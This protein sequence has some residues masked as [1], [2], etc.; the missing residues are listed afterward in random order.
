MKLTLL[1][2][3][4]LLASA[5]GQYADFDHEEHL[6]QSPEPIAI[7]ARSSSRIPRGGGY[8]SAPIE[9]LPVS[10]PSYA[11]QQIETLPN[12]G[13]GGG[14]IAP[15]KQ[16]PYS[17]GGG[18]LIGGGGGY[19]APIKKEP[20]VAPNYGGGGTGYPQKPVGGD[21]Y[22]S[23]V[24][25]ASASASS[26]GGGGGY[27]SAPLKP[28]EKPGSGYAPGYGGSGQAPF[29]EDF[30]AGGYGKPVKQEQ[31]IAPVPAYGGG[32]QKPYGGG[33]G[34][35]QQLYGHRQPHTQ[36]YGSGSGISF[37][38]PGGQY[39]SPQHGGYKQEKPQP[40]GH[41]GG[42]GGWSSAA[43]S[44]SASASGGG[45]GYDSYSKPPIVQPGYGTPLA[46]PPQKSPG[47]YGR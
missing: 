12:Y 43:S 13:G 11:N 19:G 20:Y 46:P 45:G 18:G 24:V 29:K 23:S 16:E 38:N 44:A 34:G 41:G 35:G 9:I 3:I 4:A 31:Y 39:G 6:F 42:G 47:G 7:F 37:G 36:G 27:G 30:G 5:Q 26:S 32:G 14:E 25:S 33:S 22:Q 40:G 2:F 28:V 1:S 21:G 17:G 10:G 15:I 8:G